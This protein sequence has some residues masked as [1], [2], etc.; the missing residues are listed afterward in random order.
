MLRNVLIS[1]TL[2]AG[3]ASGGF[4]QS[5][6]CTGGALVNTPA[7]LTTLLSGKTVC[8]P[9]AGGW[10]WQE[11]HLGTGE[12][13][14]FKRGPGHAT[15]PR[16]KVGTWAVSGTGANTVVRHSYTGGSSYEYKVCLAGGTSVGF[17]PTAGGATIMATVKSGSLV[18]CP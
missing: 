14:D 16:E 15:D 2:T 3:M 9:N 6:A 11:E 17:C 12:L 5:C 18:G 1:L 4:A 8:V 10:E 7:A 13:F